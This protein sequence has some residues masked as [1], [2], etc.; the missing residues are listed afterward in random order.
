MNDENAPFKYGKL[1]EE[2]DFTDRETETRYLVTNFQSGINTILISPRRWGKSSLVLKASQTAQVKNRQL[3]FCLI[4]LFKVRTEEEFY[5]YLAQEVVRCTSN[6]LDDAFEYTKK[7][8]AKFI[9]KLS[10]NPDVNSEISLSMDWKEVKKNPDDILNLAEKIAAEKKIKMV[11]CID[12]FQ[13]ISEFEDPL[14][15]QKK[16]R[17]NW[18]K[19]KHISYCLYG[20]KRH[21]MMEVFTSPSAPF[22]KFG[23]ILFLEKIKTTDWEKFIMKRFA[24]TG[25]KIEPQDATLIAT[26]VENHPYYVQQL[27]QQSW[28]RTARKCNTAIVYDAHENLVRQMSLL[29]HTITDSLST[30]QVNFLH[31]LIDDVQKVSSRLIL[32]TYQLGTSANI[33]RIRE[34]LLEKEIIDMHSGKTEFTDPLY[35]SWLKKYY[36]GR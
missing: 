29:F 34:A 36:F 14:S 8:M 4:D 35:K 12:E 6:K 5:H 17:S 1:A 32:D 9:P 18:Q 33:P 26:L 2:Q 20:S 22:Y 23:D 24:D 3:K 15:F 13:N 30:T 31:T 10:V 16:L 7:F 28:L 25:K 19:H 11:I 21:M 27:A